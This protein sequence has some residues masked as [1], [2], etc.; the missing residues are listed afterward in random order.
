MTTPPKKIGNDPS[1]IGELFTGEAH[2]AKYQSGNWIAN[3]LV[4]DFMAAV[5]GFVRTAGHT[6]VH[7][8]G[9]GEGH[10]LGVL[11]K[12]GFSVRGCD[13]SE[14]SLAVAAREA[15][16][17]GHHIPLAKQSIYDLEPGRDSADTVVC[18]EVL[19]H[20]TDPEA[21]LAQLVR[22]TRKELIVSV[23]N[24]PVWHILNMLRG[25]Y[26]TAL[27]NTPGHYQ[28]WSRRQFVAF[29]GQ[30]AE[31]LQVSKPLPWTIIRCRP[32]K[33]TS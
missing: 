21:A 19:E 3:K 33:G 28:H 26:L 7:E 11:A 24:E 27:G 17:H 1:H 29:V 9:C 16:R 6:D 23:P 20:L 15:A 2:A 5:L 8:I 4:R 12:N 31:V 25:K 13:I 10:I 30:H 32:R 22:I 18:C 14:S